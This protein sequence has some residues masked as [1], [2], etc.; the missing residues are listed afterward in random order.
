MLENT[1]DKIFQE[2]EFIETFELNG[3]NIIGLKLTR[4]SGIIKRL[5]PAIGWKYDR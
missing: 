3:K 5:N 2:E 4:K 1:G